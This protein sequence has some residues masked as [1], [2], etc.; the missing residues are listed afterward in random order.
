MGRKQ[1]DLKEALLN[2]QS[3][4]EKY[5]GS[6]QTADM[7]ETET[8]R[9]LV[10]PL[11]QALGWDTEKLEC[12]RQ[13]WRGAKS[14]GDQREAD[15]ALFVEG[16]KK[17]AVLVEA[18]RFRTV[19]D[20]GQPLT[21]TLTYAF[22]NGVEWCVLTNGRSVTV[23]DAFSRDS[24]K[25]RLLFEA[26]ELDRLDSA[27]G[28]SS[29]RAA[30]LLAMFTPEGLR[31]NR[32][33]DFRE[34]HRLKA[35]VVSCV[36]EMLRKPSPPL[37]KLVAKA[38]EDRYGLPQ[39]GD[40][41]KGLRLLR[42]DTQLPLRRGRH[43]ATPEPDRVIKRRAR[44]GSKQAERLEHWA[45]LDTIIC[46]AREGGFK[47]EFLAR[48]RWF[49]IRINPDRIPYI[50]YI[51]VYRTR[52]VAAITHYGKVEAIEPWENSGKYIVK[53]KYRAKEI[54][55][56]PGSRSKKGA[57]GVQAPRFT[58]FE[59]LSSAKTLDDCVAE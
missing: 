5:Q 40:C 46:P 44:R 15:Y 22:L 33:A 7:T 43:K 39:I 20:R 2:L 14:A 9:L 25:D 57:K 28:V 17:P 8:R 16:Q 53:L 58:S 52:P 4:I 18:K 45:K 31:A 48:K 3:R 56:I 34:S 10:D 47:E 49:A 41:L 13:G 54:G 27:E 36:E 29:D 19:L 55:P 26:I 42:G 1:M 30:A 32:P 21:Q 38:L 24:V 12:V 50:K 35:D 51:A 6:G 59:A 11:V 37:V 23:Y